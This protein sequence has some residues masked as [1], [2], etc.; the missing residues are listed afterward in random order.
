MLTETMEKHGKTHEKCGKS[1]D[2]FPCELFRG[3]NM[4]IFQQEA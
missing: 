4:V 2:F 3:F 1:W